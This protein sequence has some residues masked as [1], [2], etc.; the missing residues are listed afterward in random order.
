MYRLLLK[1]KEKEVEGR[2]G[3]HGD[4]DLEKQYS[5]KM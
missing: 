1:P 5:V 4:E 2:G 3:L